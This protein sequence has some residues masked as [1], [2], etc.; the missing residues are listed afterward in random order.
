MSEEAQAEDWHKADAGKDKEQ[1]TLYGV[2]IP[3][4]TLV[5]AVYSDGGCPPLNQFCPLSE[6][7]MIYN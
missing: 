6:N 7:A 3:F 5:L 4:H 2:Y 1:D